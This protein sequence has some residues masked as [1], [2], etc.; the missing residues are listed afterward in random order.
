[1][2][3][4]IAESIPLYGVYWLDEPVVWD[5]LFSESGLLFESLGAKCLSTCE[6][7]NTFAKE[8]NW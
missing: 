8:T 1:M 4:H 3:T 5:G 7:N 6:I 2:S